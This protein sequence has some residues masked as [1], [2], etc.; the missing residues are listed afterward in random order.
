MSSDCKSELAGVM[1]PL[2]LL[3]LM[4]ASISMVLV[5]EKWK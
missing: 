4:S 3:A 1:G 5:A 2:W